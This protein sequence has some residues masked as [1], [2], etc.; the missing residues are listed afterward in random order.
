MGTP[1]TRRVL[2]TG[3]LGQD[4]SYLAERL[5]AEGLEVHGL[6][7]PTDLPAPQLDLAGITVHYGDIAAPDALRGLIGDLA[8]AEIYNLAGMSSI[9]ACWAD[10]LRCAQVNGA[11]VATLIDAAWHVQETQGS[12]VRVVQASSA[13]MFGDPATSPQDESTPLAPISPYGAA[14]TYAHHLCAVYRQ[15]GLHAVGAI[16]FNHESPRR[17]TDFVTRKI[18][19]GAAAIAQGRQKELVL[20]NLD[21]IRDW[22]WAP[23]YVDAMVRMARSDVP[24]DYVVATGVGHAVRDFVSAAFAAAGIDTWQEFVRSDPSLKPPADSRALV[25]DSFR[26]RKDLGWQM[27]KNFEQLV[28]AMVAS[29]LT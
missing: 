19:S 12:E 15:R 21:S 28:G 20:G 5:V 13:A 23:D 8:P 7:A 1:S 3:I 25:G 29:D 6:A 10:P 24:R 14:K 4:G 17:P 27:T 16:L 26:L 11:A 18:T 9:A 2:I 22:G